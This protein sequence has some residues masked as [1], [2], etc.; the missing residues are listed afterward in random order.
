VPKKQQTRLELATGAVLSF[1]MAAC[2]VVFVHLVKAGPES[3]T[4]A[5]A[6]EVK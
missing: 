6:S 3:V 5:M 2:L 1:W 4:Q